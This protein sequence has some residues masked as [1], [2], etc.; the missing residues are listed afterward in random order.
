MTFHD[1]S[2]VLNKRPFEPFTVVTSDG[3]RYD[4]RHPEMVMVA[5]GSLVIGYP[6]RDFPTVQERY[7]IVSMGHVVR[8]EPRPELAATQGPNGQES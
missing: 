3:V 1:V 2:A 4:V 7:D 5:V 8:L 6:N